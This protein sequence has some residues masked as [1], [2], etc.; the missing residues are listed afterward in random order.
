MAPTASQPVTVVKGLFQCCP[1]STLDARARHQHQH[2]HSITVISISISITII[3]IS[4]AQHQHQ[5][6]CYDFWLQPWSSSGHMTVAQWWIWIQFL[7]ILSCMKTS[8][9]V[10]DA[11]FPILFLVLIPL[12]PTFLFFPSGPRCQMVPISHCEPW[13]QEVW[14]FQTETCCRQKIHSPE[15]SGEQGGKG[16][17]ILF[18]RVYTGYTFGI[19][20]V[21]KNQKQ[22]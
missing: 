15:R 5:G 20:L 18:N 12:F 14:L 3:S 22:Y 9:F 21:M 2:Q 17:E 11:N 7:H 10:H 8:E 4:I 16:W 13:A 1:L 6:V 19:F